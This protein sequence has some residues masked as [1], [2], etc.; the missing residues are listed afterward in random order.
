MSGDMTARMAAVKDIP[1]ARLIELIRAEAE[2]RVV[3]RPSASDSYLR[4]AMGIEEIIQRLDSIARK[5]HAKNAMLPDGW[6]LD[7]EIVK[8]EAALREA[9]D[10]LRTHQDAQPNEPLTLEELEKMDGQPVYVVDRVYQP[11]SG[12]WI[13]GWTEDCFVLAAAK[14]RGIQYIVQNY[15]IDWVAYRR[16]PKEEA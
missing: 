8:D 6:P 5:K 3:I 1:T 12:W 9:I 11:Y 4:A 2:G 15:G 13:I 7:P 10:L 16:P 14:R